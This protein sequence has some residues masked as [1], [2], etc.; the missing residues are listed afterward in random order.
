MNS[1]ILSILNEQSNSFI[2]KI[3]NNLESTGTTKS[4]K[5]AGSIYYKFTESDHGDKITVEVIGARPY[6]ATVETGRK[7]TP[8]KKPSRAMID[9]IT[10][11]VNM[12]GKPESAVWA[13]ATN[14]QNKGTELFQKGGRKD[15]YS[16]EIDGFIDSIG[17]AIAKEVAD[18]F[19]DN[20]V[21]TWNVNVSNGN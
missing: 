15:I 2:Q 18:E 8:D 20:M 1:A 13:I 4:G 10:A 17:A 7:A 19:L 12:V 5:S 21:K 14:I 6:F 3:R 9:N 16:N 11:W